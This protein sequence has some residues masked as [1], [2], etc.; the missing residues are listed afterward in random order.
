MRV[1]AKRRRRLKRPMCARMRRE[2]SRRRLPLRRR[3][4]AAVRLIG[5]LERRRW[6]RRRLY[7]RVMRHRRVR[8]WRRWVG[9]H[10][11]RVVRVVM[12]HGNR[13]YHRRRHRYRRRHR[14]LLIGLVL[15]RR[16]CPLRLVS[17]LFNAHVV[18]GVRL[19]CAVVRGRRVVGHAL[20]LLVGV[21]ELLQA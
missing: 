15:R 11:R 6:W 21:R 17:R 10:R 19:V 16:R 1:S 9:H 13:R 12:V 8:D 18:V 5:L 2:L 7:V 3:I 4:H 20:W 14:H